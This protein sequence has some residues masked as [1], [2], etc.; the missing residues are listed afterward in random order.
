VLRS[1]FVRSTAAAAAVAAPLVPTLARAQSN[2]RS[3]AVSIVSKTANDWP[4]YIAQAQGYDVAN[5]VKFDVSVAG[6]AATSTQQLVA[7]ALDIAGNSTSQALEALAGGASI[8]IIAVNDVAV[9]Y[10]IMAKKSIGTMSGL[11]GKTFI[12][13]GPN[14]ITRVYADAALARAG[15]N[16]ADVSY[17]FSGGSAD[18]FAALLS[19]GVD[20]A[21]LTPPFSFMAESHGFTTLELVSK[22]YSSFPID[23]FTVNP[24][25]ARA[26]EAVVVAFVKAHLLAVRD[27]Y[28]VTLRARTIQTLVDATN[29][30]PDDAAKTYDYL[31]QIKFFSATAMTNAA[32]MN[33]VIDTLIKTGDVKPPVP[34]FTKLTDFSYAQKAAAQLKIGG[35]R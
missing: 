20:A 34:P 13:G 14:D 11:K 32:D 15:V 22:Y 9:P 10:A 7:G 21:I 5:G 35:A 26:N 33:H 25:W 29:A 6:S 30:K 17:T 2:P 4:I 16:P 12:V 28:D 23:N 1:H 18:R 8:T 3:V 31:R 19:G 27:F 24:V